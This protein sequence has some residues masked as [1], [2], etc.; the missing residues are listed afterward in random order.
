VADENFNQKETNSYSENYNNDNIYHSNSNTPNQNYPSTNNGGIKNIPVPDSNTGQT[1]FYLPVPSSWK[2][3][4]NG[5]KGPN[6]LHAAE[7]VEMGYKSQ[8]NEAIVSSQEVIHGISQKIKEIGFSITSTK[9]I[10]NIAQNRKR[11]DA[12]QYKAGPMTNNFTATGIEAI[13]NEREKV[14]FIIVHNTSQSQFHRCWGFEV[15]M[16]RA[17][18]SYF[19]TGKKALIYA[20]SNMKYDQQ[21]INQWNQQQKAQIHAS[22]A[23]FQTRMANNQRNFQIQNNAIVGAQNEVN[24]ISMAGYKSRNRSQDNIQRQQIQGIYGN[25]EVQDPN[26]GTVYEVQG[27]A[28]QYWVDGQGNYISTD[29]VNWNPNT[30]PNYN[31]R[32]WSQAQNP[33]G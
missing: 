29:D 8:M 16:V 1:M 21:Y 13:S 24:A 18:D 7:M 15:Q 6:G 20:L 32:Q 23:S 11:M 4:P 14:I 10:P 22:N 25:S 27:Q 3:T 19:E 26:S 28:K 9:N 12:Q 33:N 2:I 31:G 17:N 30:D 5:F